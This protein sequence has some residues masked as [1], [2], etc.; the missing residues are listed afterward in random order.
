MERASLADWIAAARLRSLIMSVMPVVCTASA[1]WFAAA[2]GVQDV[3]RAIL[4][5]VAAVFIQMSANFANDYSEGKRDIRLAERSG[6]HTD[7][8]FK[9]FKHL[10]SAGKTSPGKVLFAALLAAVVAIAAGIALAVMNHSVVIIA[11]GA[12]CFAAGWFYVGGKHPYGY[13]GMGE[14]F[15]FLF[16]GVVAV[17][18]TAY[19]LGI[20]PSMTL[21]IVLTIVVCGCYPCVLL[22]VNNIRDIE[23]DTARGKRT[24]AVIMGCKSALVLQMIFAVIAYLALVGVMFIF[25]TAGHPFGIWKLLAVVAAMALAAMTVG[26][27]RSTMKIRYRAAYNFS[28]SA[29]L[30]VA[31]IYVL[32]VVQ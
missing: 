27:V 30:T 22:L 9:R 16:F 10:T 32:S 11:V 29:V 15:V 26:A 21:S 1:V 7:P 8:A 17:L 12:V 13:A 14:L 28:C 4:C 20:Q 23:R 3:V 2:P 18:G 5:L 6:A 19:V 25:F 31:I 24:L